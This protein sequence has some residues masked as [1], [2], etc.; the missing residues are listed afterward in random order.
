MKRL[1]I[2]LLAMVFVS[3]VVAQQVQISYIESSGDWYYV[4]DAKGKRLATL[5]SSSAGEVVGWC[6]SFFITK[7]GSFYKIRDAKGNIKKTMSVSYVGTVLGVSGDTFTSRVG[8]FIYT[9]DK[10]G[11]RINTRS[12]PSR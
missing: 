1:F 10:N 9:W 12:A 6:G 8:S 5:S 3:N 4:Y 7:S 2:A 11:K